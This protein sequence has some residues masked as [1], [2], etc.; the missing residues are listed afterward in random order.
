[1]GLFSKKKESHTIEEALANKDE[2]FSYTTQTGYTYEDFPFLMQQRLFQNISATSFDDAFEMYAPH[3]MKIINRIDNN[4]E[5]LIKQNQ[6]LQLK[7]DELEK[8]LNSIKGNTVH[9]R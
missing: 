1:M 2:K 7:C 9:S 4:M 3:F 6:L 5:L 8:E